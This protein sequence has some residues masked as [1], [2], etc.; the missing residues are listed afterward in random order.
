MI[1]HHLEMVKFAS[2][3]LLNCP[4]RCAASSVTLI[5][6]FKW[7]SLF[8]ATIPS[9]SMSRYCGRA[10]W[11]RYIKG[12]VATSASAWH[13]HRIRLLCS[14]LKWDQNP[15][16][17]SEQ[18]SEWRWGRGWRCKEDPLDEQAMEQEMVK[19][20]H[21]HC[22]QQSDNLATAASHSLTSHAFSSLV[23]VLQLQSAVGK[24]QKAILY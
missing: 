17:H 4:W 9:G 24:E 14:S 23:T 13:K 19:C 2:K 6:L 21:M 15:V 8:I 22:R 5:H 10:I 7:S 3:H 1:L 11:K 16:T 18:Q 20:F 12:S